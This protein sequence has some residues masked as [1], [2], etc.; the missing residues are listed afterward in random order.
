M[1]R[2]GILRILLSGAVSVL[3]CAQPVLVLAAEAGPGSAGAGNETVEAYDGKTGSFQGSELSN[4][5]GKSADDTESAGSTEGA[6]DM[7]SAGSTEGADDKESAGS[8]EGADDKESAGSTESTG[9]KENTDSTEGTGDKESTGDTESEEETEK[10]VCTCAERCA[11]DGVDQTCPVCGAE[12]ADLALCKGSE[13]GLSEDDTA[14]DAEEKENGAVRTILTWEWIDPEEYLT[15]DETA[16]WMLALPG[17]GEDDPV[18]FEDVVSMLPAGILAVV[19][20]EQEEIAF[21][22]WECEDY[23]ETAGSGDYSFSAGLPEGY[24]LDEEAKALIV[25]V[26]LGGGAVRPL[27]LTEEPFDGTLGE[28]S[29]YALTD[30]DGTVTLNGTGEDNYN[31][32]WNADDATLTLKDAAVIMEG[33]NAFVYAGEALSIVLEGENVIETTV[34]AGIKEHAYAIENG[35]GSVEISG[36]GSLDISVASPKGSAGSWEKRIGGIYAAGGFTNLAT[37]EISVTQE[38]SSESDSTHIAGI[39]CGKD[40]DGADINN[41]GKLKITVDKAGLGTW[42]GVYTWGIFQYGG[43]FSNSGTMEVTVSAANGSAEGYRNN[44]EDEEISWKNTQDGSIEINVTAYGG[45]VSGCDVYHGANQVNGIR[46]ITVP[47]VSTSLEFV[48]E[49][50]LSAS[51]VNY[52]DQQKYEMTQGISLEPRVNA[53][54]NNSGTLTAKGLGGY[55]YGICLLTYTGDAVLTNSGELTAIATTR[56][57]YIMNPGDY[58]QATGI[59]IM[60]NNYETAP[61]Q[62]KTALVL[63]KGSVTTASANASESVSEEEREE[64]T[65]NLCQAILLQKVYNYGDPEYDESPQ[66]ISLANDLVILPGGEYEGGKPLT[67]WL[68][69]YA[70]YYGMWVYINTIGKYFTDEDG[71]EFSVPSKYVRIEPGKTSDTSSDSGSAS[72]GDAAGEG[73]SGEGASSASGESSGSG[74][75]YRPVGSAASGAG[76]ENPFTDVNVTDSFYQDVLLAWKSGLMT[77]TGAA[78]FSPYSAAARAE[79]AAVFYRMAGS[80]AVTGQNS[81]SD[82]EYNADSAWYYDAVTWAEQNGIL[83]GIADGMFEPASAVT[84]EQIALAFYQYAKH[85][86]YDVT[87]VGSVDGFADKDRISA[88]ARNAVM[89]AVGAGL[90]DGGEMQLLEPQR[91]ITRAEFAGMICRFLEKYTIVQK[92]SA[93]PVSGET[94]KTAAIGTSPATGDGAQP[95]LWL[96]A[97]CASCSAAAAVFINGAGRKKKGVR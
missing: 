84:R 41:E 1:K 12:D 78:S 50:E 76:V 45:T 39:L 53:T 17:A 25:Q 70:T 71:T 95:V 64:I 72:S 56:G 69:D 5:G 74:Y 88:W 40:G 54:L 19:G 94:G 16:G 63:E 33:P 91:F 44:L 57:E 20:D 92:D 87:A 62:L 58:Q 3:L 9:D 4:A 83:E 26:S 35:E 61:N 11:E 42:Y 23:P 60:L 77:G 86:G 66:E 43:S 31:I 18:A 28:M 47:N 32:C 59:A 85:M 7:E 30:E 81:F 36:G 97:I 38:K 29:F 22:G 49:G 8:T 93:V 46:M 96:L 21:D 10:T 52:S 15:F 65:N 75:S 51:A 68:E 37:V 14:S 73:S 13:G 24:A 6:G 82:V 27:V 55:G 34:P 90:L 48:N 79:M 80:P 67:E 89:W 2:K